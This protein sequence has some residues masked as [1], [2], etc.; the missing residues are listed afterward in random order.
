MG[1]DLHRIGTG[2]SSGTSRTGFG[3]IV[4]FPSVAPSFPA[5]GTFNSWSYD[6]TYPI[7]NGG[8]TVTVDVAYPSQFCDVQLKNDGSGG[9]YTDWTTAT[10]VQYYAMGTSLTTV[11]TNAS[12]SFTSNCNGNFTFSN[13]NT[14]SAYAHD[15]S[16]GYYS[17]AG[18]NNYNYNGYQFYN[19]TCYYDDGNGGSYSVTTTYFSDGNGGYYTTTY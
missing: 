6:V 10:D 19:E 15:G 8:A 7:A 13:G 5:Y 11:T 4:S 12:V 9:T 16:G 17:V 18:G 3:T 1:V 14:W 2:I